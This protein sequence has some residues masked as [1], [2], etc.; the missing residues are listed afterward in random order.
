M[1][2]K[3]L[4]S[5]DIKLGSIQNNMKSGLLNDYGNNEAKIMVD[6]DPILNQLPPSLLQFVQRP[7]E[8]QDKLAFVE[9]G[10]GHFFCAMICCC[11][12][13][14]RC[15]LVQ[16]GQIALTQNGSKPELLGPGRHVLLSP[17]NSLIRI[18]SLTSPKIRHGPIHI[19]RVEM[20]QLGYAVDADTGQPILLTR[21]KH[22]INSQ[23]FVF[24]K[25]ISLTSEITNL[26][27]LSVIR[28]E[29]GYAGYAY[30]R[31]KLVILQPGLHLIEPPDRYGGKLSTQ[32]TILNLPFQVYETSDYVPLGIK[33]AVFYRIIDPEKA[34]ISIQ[35]ISKQ[36]E[37][38]AIATL[39]GIIR[40]SSLAD[41][42]S[43]SQPFHK[44][45]QKSDNMDNNMSQ[46]FEVKPSAPTFFEHVHDEFISLL[47]DHCKKD[48]GI[49]IQNIRIEQMKIND[50]NLQKKISQQAIEVSRL[51][52]QYI[53]LQKSREITEVEA[54]TKAKQK[55]IQTRANTN[56][57]KS[58][59]MAEAESIVIKAEAKKKARILEGEGEQ[60][61]SEK[62]GKSELGKILATM[63]IQADALKG[64]NQVAY[65]PHLPHLLDKNGIFQK[66]TLLG[67]PVQMQ[68]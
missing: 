42:A 28:I 1:L 40:S 46:P 35:N 66:N 27:K 13:I 53:M 51:H 17:W 29:T 15:F 6:D 21:G 45:E 37:E 31:G 23:T 61:Y 58:L 12:S 63:N 43:Q 2:Q 4:N 19:I 47:A 64:L 26:D 36:I 3:R 20:G 62:V 10:C 33:A 18:E 24:K 59:A 49:E 7:K 48:W 54:Q 60:M 44:S 14:C 22:T 56:A 8:H 57:T 68:L 5:E 9:H 55:E 50:I 39:G 25:F 32:L 65:I 34:L 52:T 16:Q 67:K 41:V 11:Y 30:R 38:T